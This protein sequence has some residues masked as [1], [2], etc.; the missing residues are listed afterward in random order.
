M[1]EEQINKLT[2]HLSF[3]NL[4]GVNIDFF[5]LLVKLRKL[6]LRETHFQDFNFLFKHSFNLI[7]ELDLSNNHKFGSEI[8]ILRLFSN[9]KG[10]IISETNLTSF[11]F[12][13]I[14]IHKSYG[15]C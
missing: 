4:S 3:D 11:D 10:I 7:E 13:C 9:L 15:V 1:T 5:S 12:K 2:N 6:N 8:S 14:Q